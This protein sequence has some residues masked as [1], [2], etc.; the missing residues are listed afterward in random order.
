MQSETGI[1]LVLVLVLLLATS[2]IVSHKMGQMILTAKTSASFQKQ[3]FVGIEAENQLLEAEF[4]VK[5]NPE[6]HLSSAIGFVADHLEYGCQEGVQIF[7]VSVPPL[8]SFVAVRMNRAQMPPLLNKADLLAK[9]GQPL[10]LLAAVDL[11]QLGT[12]DRLYATDQNYIWSID[13]TNRHNGQPYHQYRLAGLMEAKYLSNL[14]VV[15]DA[16]GNGVCLYF[17]SEF[18]QKKGLYMIKDLLPIVNSGESL[19]HALSAVMLIAEGDYRAFFV[20][21]GRIVLIPTDPKCKPKALALP[22]HQ[23]ALVDDQLGRIAWRKIK[24]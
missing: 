3:L 2:L 5:K 7:K 11:K 24:K 18:T 22:T 20:R 9:A 10:S 19:Q 17:L 8:E 14:H 15:P 4:K 21:F 1:V 23:H 16:E 12:V 13:L 6:R